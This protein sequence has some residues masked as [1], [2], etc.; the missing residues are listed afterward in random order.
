[1]CI[2]DSLKVPDNIFYDNDHTERKLSSYLGRGLVLNFWATWC[3]PCVKEMPHLDKLRPILKSSNFDVLAVSEDRNGLDLIR[4]FFADNSLKNLE[5]LID[6]KG[7]LLQAAGG[8]GLP[9][10]LLID[11]QGYEV[12]RL[13]GIAEWDAPEIIRF[14]KR[15]LGS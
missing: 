5:I 1:M 9:T 2:R 13:L 6:Q 7:K 10:T 8:R 14:L 12:G 11:R 15:C 4:S 3:A